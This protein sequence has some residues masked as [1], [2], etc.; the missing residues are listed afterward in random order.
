MMNF[1]KIFFTNKKGVHIYKIYMNT[2][3]DNYSDSD[4]KTLKCKF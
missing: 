1:W 2:A 3:T 4:D